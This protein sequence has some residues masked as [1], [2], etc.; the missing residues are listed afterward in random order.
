MLIDVENDDVV[1]QFHRYVR[2]TYHLSTCYQHMF[3]YNPTKLENAL[4][5]RD[6]LDDF[7]EWIEGLHSAYDIKLV[8]HRKEYNASN[9]AF[10]CLWNGQPLSSI[11]PL[12]A[13]EKK[14]SYPD[15]LKHW[16]SMHAAVK[17]IL[18][19]I[20]I[21]YHIIDILLIFS[22]SEFTGKI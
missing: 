22:Y 11:L 15:Y 7:Y 13:K 8:D 17:V 14:F 9:A 20:Q 2:P 3:R 12:E 4:R 19:Y 16:I 1:Q 10:I 21:S 6:A 18:I 5:I